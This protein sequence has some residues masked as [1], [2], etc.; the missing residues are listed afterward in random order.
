M[1]YSQESR[2]KSMQGMESTN[3]SSSFLAQLMLQDRKQFFKIFEIVKRWGET[4][5]G[6]STD[7]DKNLFLE[8]I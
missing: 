3:N 7:T 5:H 1:K 6:L 4:Q 2:H 8:R